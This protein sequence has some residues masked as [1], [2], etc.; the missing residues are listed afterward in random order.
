[1]V[2]VYS[3][4]LVEMAD[5]NAQ[6]FGDS[7]AMYGRNKYNRERQAKLDSLEQAKSM[8]AM[9]E[10]GYNY[11]PQ[12]NTL[13]RSEQF[14]SVPEGY[15]RFGGKLIPDRSVG[16]QKQILD[17][18]LAA[19]PE[20]QMNDLQRF[21]LEEK[22]KKAEADAQKQSMQDDILK[23][24]TED[25]IKTIEEVKKTPQYFGAL[26]DL[27]SIPVVTGDY[28]KRKNWETNVNKLLSGRVLDIM[29]QMKQA[30]RTGAT[31]FG[32]L[33]QKELQVLQNASTALKRNLSK[34]DAMRYLNDLEG[35]YQRVLQ[36]KGMPKFGVPTNSEPEPNNEDPLGLLS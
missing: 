30:S 11:D 31:G 6:R 4:D 21:T 7:L 29:N 16:Y 15:Q 32:Q 25:T 8:I 20:P 35:T 34:E 17:Q 23:D 2:R 12:N 19:R 27:P 13:S 1:M 5:R 22:Q 26:G 14:G 18:K 24:S 9:Q 28:G 36:R 3:D 10:A 33:S